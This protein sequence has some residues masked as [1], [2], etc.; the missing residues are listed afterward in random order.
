VSCLVV[1]LDVL[2]GLLV[3]L[4]LCF[5]CFVLFYFVLFCHLQPDDDDDLIASENENQLGAGKAI[6]SRG[7]KDKSNMPSRVKKMK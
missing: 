3:Y 2:S 4:V 1:V 6:P 7:K 5:S